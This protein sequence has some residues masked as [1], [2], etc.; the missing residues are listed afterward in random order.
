MLELALILLSTFL[1]YKTTKHSVREHNE[2]TWD[3]IKEVAILFIGIFI[4]M[5]PALLILEARGSSL[6]LT[7]CAVFLGNRCTV[8]LSG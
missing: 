8:Q 5:I 1:S 2:F 6:G 4:T 3:A 7:S